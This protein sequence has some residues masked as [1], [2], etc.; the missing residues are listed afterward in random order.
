[1]KKFTAILGLA[2][3][4]AGLTLSSTGFAFQTTTSA[5]P[6][7]TAPM[8]SADKKAQKK[9]AKEAGAAPASAAAPAAAATPKAATAPASGSTTTTMAPAKAQATKTTKPVEPTATPAQIAD[10]KAKGMVWVN[11]STKVYHKS[12]DKY[13]GAT[14]AGEF[15]TEADAQKAG[16]HLAK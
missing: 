7:G 13:Y 8:T 9:A 12:G 14:K 6:P 1:M 4:F 3:M 16:A 10:A 2:T 5:P 11:T 15:M